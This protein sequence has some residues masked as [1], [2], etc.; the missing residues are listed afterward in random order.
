MVNVPSTTP[1]TINSHLKN[2][3]VITK[4]I[5]VPQKFEFNDTGIDWLDAQEI[6]DFIQTCFGE[7]FMNEICVKSISCEN[8]IYY[9]PDWIH[10]FSNTW[11]I[12]LDEFV[13]KY[14]KVDEQG[15]IKLLEHVFAGNSSCISWYF[16]IINIYNQDYIFEVVMAKAWKPL[17]YAELEYFEG[18]DRTQI[19]KLYKIW[20][21]A[22]EIWHHMYRQKIDWT[23]LMQIRENIID[24]SWGLTKYAQAYTW[25]W[26]IYYNENI[27]EA[28]RIFITNRPYLQ[29][30]FPDVDGFIVKYFP[31]VHPYHT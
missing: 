8:K 17:D 14:K 11:L 7:Q 28:I 29:K 4:K 9:A 19:P 2:K 18:I 15:K 10:D 3:I 23:K 20:T 25:K 21:I 13:S 12:P 6:R 5:E 31:S 22:H 30:N 24:K 27:W 26:L 16:T 1:D